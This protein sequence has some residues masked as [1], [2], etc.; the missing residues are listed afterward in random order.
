V[1]R[2]ARLGSVVVPVVAL[3]VGILSDSLTL[4]KGENCEIYCGPGTLLLPLFLIFIL[5]PLIW[6]FGVILA[7]LETV[8][9][10][11][12]SWRSWLGLGISVAAP[13]LVALFHRLAW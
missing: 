13:F 1:K 2:A 9:G 4:I 12:R 11:A 3:V 10:R 5:T 7:V 8:R 6:L